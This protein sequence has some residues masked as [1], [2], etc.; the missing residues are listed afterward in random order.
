MLFI[1]LLIAAVTV[2]IP[3]SPA[4]GH[5]SDAGLDMENVV[6]FEGV[7]T[8]YSMRNPHTYF[9]AMST[10]EQGEEIEWTVQMGS[11]LTVTRRGW[12]PDSLLVGDQVSVGLHRAIDGRPYG[13]IEWISKGGGE[14][15]NADIVAGPGSIVASGPPPTT[16]TIEGRWI[17]DRTS[18][19]E[20]YPGGLDQLTLA[21]LTLT[22]EGR[23]AE[24]AYS[25]N[26][27]E[28]PELLCVSKPTPS[29][30]VYTDL[31]PLEIEFNEGEETIVIRSQYFDVER[32][33]FMDGREHPA[34]NER[35]HQGHSVGHWEDD[36]L[37]VDT[38]N[39]TDHRS[40][41]QNGIPA[42]GMKHVVERYQLAEGGTRMSVEFMLEDPEYI[43]GSMTHVRSLIYSPQ[44]DMSPFNCDLEATRRF[45]PR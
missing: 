3:M 1:Y 33:V 43:V 13:L 45:V 14:V 22:E 5:H 31:Y 21:E 28:N 39:F 15:V 4:S 37:V 41:Y 20:D 8:E 42:G 27:S 35:T 34:A 19:G 7:I 17:V 25:Q 16:S 24:E 6:T 32:T 2:V 44:M 9:T 10:N 40:P 11:A 36:I 12:R 29:M 18:L 26:S 38:T 23:I 30:I